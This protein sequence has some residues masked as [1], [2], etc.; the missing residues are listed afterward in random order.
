[1]KR[2]LIIFFISTALAMLLLHYF[3]KANIRFPEWGKDAK[4]SEYK[5]PSKEILVF[6][7]SEFTIVLDANPSTGYGWQLSETIDK[8]L[9]K[10]VEI[11]HRRDKG[12]KVGAGGKDLW[13]FQALREGEGKIPFDYV[14]PWEKGVAPAKKEIFTV[15][16]KNS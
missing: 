6:S 5:D 16:I 15:R 3:Q 14:R 12:E 2:R 10:V 9:L 4:L 7:G 13:T 1:M 8:T 11:K